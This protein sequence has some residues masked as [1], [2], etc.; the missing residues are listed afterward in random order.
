MDDIVSS[1]HRNQNDGFDTFWKL[2]P[3]KVAK[4]AARKAWMKIAPG[5][6]LQQIIIDALVKQQ[7]SDQWSEWQFIPYPATWL[8]GE[9]WDDEVPTNEVPKILRGLA[10]FVER[11]V[12]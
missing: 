8:N 10:A 9:R 6:Q 11:E 7:A 1:N 12:G 4:K 2:Y 3:R 5:P